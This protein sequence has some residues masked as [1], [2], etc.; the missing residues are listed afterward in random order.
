MITAEFSL[1]ERGNKPA[2]LLGVPRGGTLFRLSNRDKRLEGFWK[3]WQ[4]HSR[5]KDKYPHIDFLHRNCTLFFQSEESRDKFMRDA[6]EWKDYKGTLRFDYNN[7]KLGLAL[8]YPP[9]AVKDWESMMFNPTADRI[10]FINYYGI[11]F[12]C[13]ESNINTCL[14]WLQVNNP[15][16]ANKEIGVVSIRSKDSSM[17]VRSFNSYSVKESVPV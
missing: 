13:Y 11:N 10:M 14:E 15:L 8:G 17:V 16:D 5:M 1:F 4:S 6:C 3:K 2:L 9:Q 7:S 12:S